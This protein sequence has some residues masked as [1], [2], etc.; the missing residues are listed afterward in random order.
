[1]FGLFKRQEKQRVHVPASRIDRLTYAIG[2]IHGRV[3]LL[4]LMVEKIKRDAKE[5][6]ERPR[7]V[8]LGDYIDRGPD[9]PEVLDEICA[10][11]RADWCDIEVL[12]GNHEE[13][14]LLFMTTPHVGPA[15][16]EHGGDATLVS[17]GLSLPQ[18]RT[19]E[20]WE[21]LSEAFKAAVPQRHVDLL[22]TMKVTFQSADYLFVHAGVK[23]GVPLAD[24]DRSAFLWIRQEFL[25][26]KKSCEY[27]VVHG[28]T[29]EPAIANDPWRIGLDTGAY[30]TGVLSAVR[31]SDTE[32]E[33]ISVP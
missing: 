24:Q 11:K 25:N 26:S 16:V 9:S 21:G 27:V 7:L 28:H 29:P 10:L 30:A 8:F 17:Y 2:D 13:S 23:P 18:G 4:R 12:M 20:D 14:M 19:R 33:F 31:L 1:M 15:W 32:R 5:R 3:D 22:E 6:N